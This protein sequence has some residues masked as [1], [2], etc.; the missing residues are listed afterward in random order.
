MTNI[1]PF[2]GR[3]KPRIILRRD[4]H[5]GEPLPLRRTG[6]IFEI[7]ITPAPEGG[8][9]VEAAGM[10]SFAVSEFEFRRWPA[11]RRR[12]EAAIGCRVQSMPDAEW[13]WIWRTAVWHP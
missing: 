6:N 13:E 8:F 3:G 10:P 2:R 4:Y 12:L 1:T 11:F 9:L 7:D 5:D